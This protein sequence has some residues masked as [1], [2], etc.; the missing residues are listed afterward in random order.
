[1]LKSK[2]L[3]CYLLL[4]SF[5]QSKAFANEI[6]RSKI[7]N[8]NLIPLSAFGE[9]IKCNKSIQQFYLNRTFEPAW[10]A[11]TVKQLII[12]LT[13]ASEEGLNPK[14]YH[15]EKI[16][17]LSQKKQ[18]TDL[19]LAEYDLLLS[20]AFLLYASH[21]LSGKVNPETIDIDWHVSKREGNPIKLLQDAI[22]AEDILS[23]IQSIL[24]KQ[25]VYSQLK[26]ALKKYELLTN[27][28][29]PSIPNGAVIK[30]GM[31]DERLNS[32][33]KKLLVL[34][35]I[36]INQTNYSNLYTNELQKGVIRFQKR[37]GLDS[38]GDIGVKTIAALNVPI[39]ERVLQIK[40]NLERWRWLQQ[41]FGSY[42]LLVNI[43][44][45]EL[46]V[47]R[48][49]KTVK[50]HKIITGK[51][52][53]KTPVFSSKMQYLVLNPTWTVPPGILSADIIPAAQK[54]PNYI[55]KKKLNVYDKNGNKLNPLNIDWNNK[56]VNSYTYRQ[57]PGPDNALGAVKFMFPNSYHV[58]LHDTPSKELFDKSERAFSSGCVR[59]QKPLE[60]A[61]FLLNDKSK[62]SLSQIEKIVA[63]K[64]TQTISLIEQPNIHLL[65]WT[66]WVDDAGLIQF[67]K[68]IYD[69]DSAL[70]SKILEAPP[71]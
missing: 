53:R 47:V 61:A 34:G 2:F 48:D 3:I 63:S 58:Y 14:D 55:N 19:L 68:D 71:L 49:G 46:D 7:E 45:F 44:N 15:F 4:F 1:M 18:N 22:S 62:W 50:N 13:K 40:A 23:A 32:I 24:P 56:I 39:Y 16:L 6:I 42:Y 11:K 67:R 64:Q 8:A 30:V 20:D 31:K 52:Y 35:D 57:D 41:E 59:V 54:D 17:S 21:L 66:A 28:D 10:N 33:S 12:A 37:H 9:T 26:V 27:Y 70:I 25:A 60:L 29:W 36:T 69:R 43:A 51:P 65:Y 5:S 38:E